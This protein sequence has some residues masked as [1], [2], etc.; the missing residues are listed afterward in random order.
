MFVFFFKIA[1]P[2]NKKIVINKD[3]IEKFSMALCII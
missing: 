3:D 2:L 1:I